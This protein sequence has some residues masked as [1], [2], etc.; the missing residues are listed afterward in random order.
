MSRMLGYA[1][2]QHILDREAA[3][4]SDRIIQLVCMTLAVLCLVGA[5]LLVPSIN[6]SRKEYQLV[7]N[8]ETIEG[9]P[10]DIQLLTKMG[11][12]RALAIDI[13]AIRSDRLKNEDKF[14]ELMQLSSWL[15]KLAPRYPSVWWNA[16]WNQAYN[17]SVTQHSPEAR[18]KWVS[19]GIRLLRDEAIRYN[20]KAIGLYENLAWTFWHK[21]GDFTDDFHWQ[22]KN[23]LAV[24]MERVLGSP[25]IALSEEETVNAFRALVEAPQDEQAFEA[26]LHEDKQVVAFIE[27]LRA[28]GLAADDTL[29]NFVARYMRN[30]IQ[31]ATLLKIDEEDQAQKQLLERAKLLADPDNTEVR[32]RLLAALRAHILRT[33]YNMDPAYM[34]ELME[35]YGP[36]DWRLPFGHSLYWSSL[37]DK[38]TKDMLRLDRDVSMRTVRLIF[39]SLNKMVRQGRLVLE[40]DFDQPNASFIQLMPDARFIRHTH[41][42][43]L[44][45]GKEQLDDPKFAGFNEYPILPNYRAGHVNFLRYAIRQLWWLGTPQARAEAREY[46]EWL[47]EYDREPNGKPKIY[48]MQPL[49]VMVMADIYEGLTSFNNA[50]PII[51]GFLNRSLDQLAI[52]DL[53][54]AQGYLNIARQGWDYYMADKADDT[55]ERRRIP[56]LPVMRRR[57]V[58]DYMQRANVPLLKKVR[59]WRHLGLDTR[60]HCYGTLLPYMTQLC[61]RHEPPLEL[62]EVFREPPE[63]TEFRKQGQQQPEPTEPELSRGE[64]TPSD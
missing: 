43:M 15:C 12:L 22:Y 9:L 7:I 38:V 60:R 5:A 17:I 30:D 41:E 10:P 1:I 59:L 46:Y 24:E 20:P 8:P 45:Y 11:T 51:N 52:G 32:D 18:W 36:I 35:E 34:L 57:M 56:P 47:R 21:V 4:R 2:P 62:S 40:P 50:Q 6:R 16:A 27:K 55:V 14:Y 25:I 44:K 33:R 13:A 29:L 61:A 37:G 48:Y 23:E 58:M 39:F 3:K 42:A 63:M 53:Q 49:E 19:N 26:F 64:K 54:M 28:V 31:I